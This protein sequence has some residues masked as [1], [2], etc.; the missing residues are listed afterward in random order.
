M[1]L[2]LNECNREIVKVNIKCILFEPGFMPGFFCFDN[3]N[4]ESVWY[5]FYSR[6]EKHIFDLM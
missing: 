1:C 5:I 4:V 2:W 6:I 3:V